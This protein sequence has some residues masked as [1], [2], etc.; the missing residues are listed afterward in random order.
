MRLMLLTLL[1]G[2]IGHLV[3]QSLE[4]SIKIL[5]EGS[6]QNNLSYKIKKARNMLGAKDTNEL[7]QRLVLLA[8]PESNLLKGMLA[9][10]L[11]QKTL[12]D[13]WI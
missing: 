11:F 5:P 10:A 3:Q 8:H 1:Q 9:Q 12:M 6:E 13:H 7:F 4:T 2:Q